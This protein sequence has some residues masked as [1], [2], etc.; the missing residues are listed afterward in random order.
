MIRYT[1]IRPVA[2]WLLL[3]GMLSGCSK[4]TGDENLFG[5]AIRLNTG[6]ATRAVVDAGDSFTAAVAG[7]ET[8]TVPDYGTASAWLSGFTATVDPPQP[9]EL[10][11]QPYYNLDDAVKTYM[12]AWHPAGALSAD[13]KVLF[14]GTPDGTVDVLLTEAVWGSRESTDAGTLEFRHLLSQ[15]RF[16]IKAAPNVTTHPTLTS[17]TVHG[18]K[19]PTGLDLAA[20]AVTYSAGSDFTVSGIEAGKVVFGTTAQGVG[21]PLLLCPF[22]G[23]T[24]MVD[25]VTSQSAYHDVVATIDGDEQFIPG[26]AYTITLTYTGNDIRPLETTVSVAPWQDVIGGDSDIWE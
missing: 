3:C 5:P 10:T 25:I 20:D 13:G 4:Q 14:G 11:P 19:L 21:I 6:V 23:K 8:P 24:F 22:A 16:R 9:V 18:V 7:W 26:K 1:K 12:K 17:L 2:A 15:L